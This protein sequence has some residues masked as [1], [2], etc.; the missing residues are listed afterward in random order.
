MHAWPLLKTKRSRFGHNGSAGSN[1]KTFCHR[2][3]PTGAN[4]IGV[5]GWPLLAACTASIERVRMVLIAS[6]SIIGTSPGVP[7]KVVDAVVAAVVVAAM[8]M[9]KFLE[10]FEDF[11]E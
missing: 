4:A 9:D 11:Q 1:F 3:Y 7:A 5:P 8:V 2:A 10:K 6:A